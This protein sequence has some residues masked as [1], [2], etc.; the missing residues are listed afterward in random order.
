MRKWGCENCTLAQRL[1]E[2]P[3]RDLIYGPEL[4]GE[5]GSEAGN[6]AMVLPAE[7]PTCCLSSE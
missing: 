4:G 6:A 2:D 3:R 5:Q 7:G 1:P